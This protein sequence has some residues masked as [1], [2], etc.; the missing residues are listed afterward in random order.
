MHAYKSSSRTCRCMWC[1][2]PR[3]TGKGFECPVTPAMREAICTWA[4]DNGY[5]WRSLL[6]DAWACGRDVGPELQRV[7]NVI[8]PSQL[9]KIPTKMVRQPFKAS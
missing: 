5:N 8:G 1:G 6:I 2:K 7:R 4:A 3:W 9:L